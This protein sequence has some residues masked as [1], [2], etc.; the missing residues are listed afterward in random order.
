MR[1]AGHTKFQ[2]HKGWFN[3]TLRSFESTP[4]SILRLDGDWYE[5][6]KFCLVK[7]FPLVSSGGLVIIDDYYTWD[8]CS[9]AVHDYLAETKCNS[10]V[11]QWNNQVAYIIKKN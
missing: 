6:I 5:S 8:G 10:R 11:R 7:L 2:L 9:K 4:I 1:I 3:E